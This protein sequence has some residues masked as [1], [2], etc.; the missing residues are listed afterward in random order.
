[1]NRALAVASTVAL[2]ASLVPAATGSVASGALA[3]SALDS[4]DGGSPIRAIP[5]CTSEEQWNCIES[6]EY[7]VDGEWRTAVVAETPS[8]G[9]AVV[10][11][12]DL[13][14]EYGR[15][16]IRAE[17]FERYD[18][19]GNMHPAYQLQLQAWPHGKYPL[20]P[21][22]L[23]CDASKEGQGNPQPGTDP[24][25]RGAWLA[26]A[27]YR[28]TFRSSRF[29]PIL[30][31]TSVVDMNTTF[32][33]IPGGVRFSL[34]GRPGASQ[35]AFGWGPGEDADTVD[36]ISYE[37][38]GLVTD[39]RGGN[40]MGGACAGLGFATAHSNGHGGRMPQWDPRTGSLS[41]GI[42]GR[43]YAPDGSIYRGR[44]EISVPGPLARCLWKVDPRQTARMEVEVLSENGEEV[45]GTKAISYEA[46]ADIVKLIATNFTYSEKQIVARPTPILVGAGQKSCNGAKTVC[47]SVDRARKA[48]R[49]ALARIADAP[50]V[51]AVALQGNS[52]DGTTQVWANLTGG[53]GSL[54]VKLAGAKSKGQVWIVRS[55]STFIASFEVK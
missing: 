54:S 55:E 13:E 40:G 32:N 49:I 53:K 5:W 17:A 24:C 47:I 6:V 42:G 4:R 14:H 26:D 28:M 25:V 27:S 50:R 44:A 8:W 38:A 31:M 20:E 10:D 9:G 33:E 30:A 36:A 21:T 39:V 11:T 3:T 45:A 37:W 41:F 2:A 15:T 12:P 23:L 16:Q 35:M 18:I 22:V 19:D 48:A 29:Q 52:E 46:V 34:S 43:H 7:F 51:A 1:M